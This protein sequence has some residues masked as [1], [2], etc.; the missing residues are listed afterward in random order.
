MS[1]KHDHVNFKRK[2]LK[3]VIPEILNS[4]Q[5]IGNVSEL[6]QSSKLED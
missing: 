2:K 4:F 1:D 3:L 5:E 6:S